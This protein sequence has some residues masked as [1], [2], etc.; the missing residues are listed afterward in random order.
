MLNMFTPGGFVY[1][2]WKTAKGRLIALLILVGA[3]QFPLVM[4]PDRFSFAGDVDL[5]LAYW[6]MVRRTIVEFYEF[7]FWGP[8]HHG[9][10]P[11][12]ANPQVTVFGIELPCLLIFGTWYG[13]RIAVY[14][15]CLYG[16]A[17]MFL[18]LGDCTKNPMGR[19]WG[20]AVFGLAGCIP[21]HSMMG[22]SS[23]V[24]ITF[25]PWLLYFERRLNRSPGNALLLGV[26]AE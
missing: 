26:T 6:E 18:F 13:W 14:L 4:T 3:V 11:L 1:C 24:C 22:H 12:F 10:V 15:Y 20:A 19:F 7:P 8:W 9:G 16:A 17:G 2:F 25:L 21:S 5:S 23:M